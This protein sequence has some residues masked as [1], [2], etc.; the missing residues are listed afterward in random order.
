ML[1]IRSLFLQI[2]KVHLWKSQ[3]ERL[4]RR[5]QKG[6]GR[7]LI[8]KRENDVVLKS[9]FMK[10]RNREGWVENAATAFFYPENKNSQ[11]KTSDSTTEELIGRSGFE[12]PVKTTTLA[13]NTCVR[14]CLLSP[15]RLEQ[16]F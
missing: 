2:T 9:S 12:L 5:T 1:P 6:I 13:T 10:R 3:T 15:A 4:T 8:K 7:N 16:L 14:A 11:R